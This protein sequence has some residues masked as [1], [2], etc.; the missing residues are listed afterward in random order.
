[1]LQG[2]WADR[3]AAEVERLAYVALGYSYNEPP[4]FGFLGL[5]RWEA[6]ATLIETPDGP[7]ERKVGT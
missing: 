2:S 7:V 3:D 6:Q 1:M 4:A 5:L